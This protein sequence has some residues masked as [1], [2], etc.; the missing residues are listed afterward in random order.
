M[1]Q[2]RLLANDEKPMAEA[3]WQYSFGD[4]PAFTSWY[5]QRRADAVYALMDD[6]DLVAQIVCASMLVDARGKPLSTSMLAG[7]T[8][9]PAYRLQG[10]MNTLTTAL[11]AWLREEDYSAAILY[12]F[13]YG[14]YQHYGFAP[15][16]E[17]ARASVALEALPNEKPQGLIAT[18]KSAD[19]DIS[20]LL[21]AYDASFG[22]YSGRALRDEAAFALLLEEHGLDGGFAAVYRRDGK[23][24]GYLL[25]S[26][27]GKAMAVRE[28]GCA[29][30]AA[31]A[32]LLCFLK[33]HASSMDTVEFVCP[34]DDPLW[35]MLPDPRGLVSA[36]PY[37]MYRV[38]DI[39][40][41]LGGLPAGEGGITLRVT[42]P[43]ASWND[44]LWHLASRGGTLE[45]EKISQDGAKDG[46]WADAPAISI[47]ML[48]QWVFGYMDGSM[49]RQR[50]ASLSPEQAQAMDKLL[51]VRP[52]FVY[53][54]Y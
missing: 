1:L 47:G 27:E 9:A 19:A 46:D 37:A 34:L 32:D 51:P 11:F 43:C 48:A 41:A 40:R 28:I 52:V 44:G 12:P 22:R 53:E 2:T 35:Q 33:G 6:G 17:I 13:D 8:T 23:E 30:Q 54:M 4:G 36:E 38:V 31:R 45:A 20:A 25:Y 7:I 21:R 5:F 49:L 24:E 18:S 15:C 3:L 14:Y 42:D 26:L 10:H 29:S 39:E 16:G 50:G